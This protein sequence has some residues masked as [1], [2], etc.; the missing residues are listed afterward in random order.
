MQIVTPKLY[1]YIY[2]CITVCISSFCVWDYG[3]Y[4][5]ENALWNCSLDCNLREIIM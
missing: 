2:T 5:L 4:E 1:I 3:V